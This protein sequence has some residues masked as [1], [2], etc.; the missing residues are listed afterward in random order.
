MSPVERKLVGEVDLFVPVGEA[1]P[2]TG[3]L[4]PRTRTS[5]EGAVVGMVHNGWPSW[6]HTL[7]AFDVLLKERYGVVATIR[8][9][10]PEIGSPELREAMYEE[11]AKKCDVVIT[12][13]G[14]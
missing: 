3:R 9:T 14:H 12:G 7:D 1:P 5:L 13:L 10:V 8:R 4:A 11:F 2:S 6:I